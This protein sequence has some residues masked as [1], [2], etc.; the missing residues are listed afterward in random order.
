MG[1]PRSSSAS[2]SRHIAMMWWN[3]AIRRKRKATICRR[4][5]GPLRSLTRHT[6]VARRKRMQVLTT[7]QQMR[8]ACHTARSDG[9]S[10]GLVP[11]MGALHAGHLSLVRA[12]RAECDV[13]AVSIFVNPTQ[14][15]P[16]ED[17][18]KYP[19]TFEQDCR[20]LEDEGV[21]LVFAPQP[22]EMYRPG[23]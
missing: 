10:L 9:K 22:E 6:C 8:V 21:V 4:A 18:A 17:F 3:A 23:A 5:P 16:N 11:T 20:L 14:F 7:I 12:A 19:R 13:V 15:G 1:M 2:P